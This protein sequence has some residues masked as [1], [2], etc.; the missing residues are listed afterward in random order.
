MPYLPGVTFTRTSADA[1]VPT[2]VGDYGNIWELK[3]PDNPE[4]I[5]TDDTTILNPHISITLP[6]GY[7]CYITET[8]TGIAGCTTSGVEPCIIRASGSIVVPIANAGASNEAA[9]PNGALCYCV[10]EPMVMA[11]PF[12]TAAIAP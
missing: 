7:Q 1:K 12:T 11:A 10:I 9:T 5:V 2:I 4:A 8:A 3:V 6:T